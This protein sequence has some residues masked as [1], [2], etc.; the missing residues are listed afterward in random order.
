[1]FH[2]GSY[3]SG[4][5]RV[6]GHWRERLSG[7]S[8]Q[9]LSVRTRPSACMSLADVDAALAPRSYFN[10]GEAS[11]GCCGSLSRAKSC[12]ALSSTIAEGDVAPLLTFSAQL[13]PTPAVLFTQSPSG[14]Q[15]S[16]DA[17][18]GNA[19]RPAHFGGWYGK[20]TDRNIPDDASAADDV[21]PPAPAHHLLRSQTRAP[22]R[23]TWLRY[24]RF[25]TDS[26]QPQPRSSHNRPR[27]SSPPSECLGGG[28]RQRI[29]AQLDENRRQ[30]V[31][32]NCGDCCDEGVRL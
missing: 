2:A 14:V 30:T 19:Q 4:H 12:A 26:R 15:P 32:V 21:P 17:L 11:C 16:K 9:G 20:L 5:H 13:T 1:V 18:Y 23:G 10:T 7:A 25:L 27:A 31:E 8:D 29:R 6:R 24:S 22:P 28:R 3:A